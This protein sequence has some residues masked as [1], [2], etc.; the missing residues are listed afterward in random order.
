MYWYWGHPKTA[1]HDVSEAAA[2]GLPHEIKGN[3]IHA[4]VILKTGVARHEHLEDE[5]KKHV[6][7]EMGPIGK[8]EKIDFVDALPKTRSGKIMR[9]VL[10]A[11]ALGEDPGNLATLEEW[12]K[13]CL[14]ALRTDDSRKA[15]VLGFEL[16]VC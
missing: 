1:A 2:I 4:F 10:R 14:A 3:A 13:T 15:S 16:F 5:L 7:H 12:G 8:P 11:R 6:G 9:R